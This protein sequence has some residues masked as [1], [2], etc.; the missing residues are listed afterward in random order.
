MTPLITFPDKWPERK[1][2]WED[3]SGMT[4]AERQLSVAREAVAREAE[5]EK[6]SQICPNCRRRVTQLAQTAL[7][8]MA[9]LNC[10]DGIS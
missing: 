5:E 7:R 3:R 2:Y 6:A 8:G 1:E 10:Y 4:D 9:C